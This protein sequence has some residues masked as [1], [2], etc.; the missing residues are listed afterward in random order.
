MIRLLMGGGILAGVVL[1]AGFVVLGN[2]H[3][4]PTLRSRRLANCTSSTVQFTL[5]APAPGGQLLL[6]LPQTSP[7][8]KP[9]P[10]RGEVVIRQHGREVLRFPVVSWKCK[11]DNW[12]EPH[13]QLQGYFL[14][15]GTTLGNAL[16]SG[17]TY[18][19]TVTFTHPPPSSASVWLAWVDW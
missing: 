5:R 4:G 12:L 16:R 11:P 8:G 19:V 1:L 15:Q 9:P 6:G 10:F 18:D 17:E 7:T 2:C 3:L 13:G 14:T